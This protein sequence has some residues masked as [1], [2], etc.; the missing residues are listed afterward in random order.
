M[1]SKRMFK[2]QN[3]MFNFCISKISN[4][5]INTKRWSTQRPSP[6]VILCANLTASIGNT[7][8]RARTYT[9]AG[10]TWRARLLSELNICELTS[11]I[12]FWNFHLSCSF[13][14]IIQNCDW[15]PYI[16]PMHLRWMPITP[17]IKFFLGHLAGEWW[18]IFKA[19]LIQFHSRILIISCG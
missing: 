8:A 2:V 15:D 1:Y 16:E 12:I 9:D 10:C 14:A 13:M 3:K 11:W 4:R 17:S 6:F 19:R 5:I 7:Y 18:N